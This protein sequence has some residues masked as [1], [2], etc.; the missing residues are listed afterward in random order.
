M[1]SILTTL[2][3]NLD[4]NTNNKTEKCYTQKKQLHIFNLRNNFF[5]T[6]CA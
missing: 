5:I 4:C 1:F 6:I 3:F 2:K